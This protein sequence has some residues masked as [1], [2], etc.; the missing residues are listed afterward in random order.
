[1]DGAAKTNLYLLAGLLSLDVAE[2]MPA[3]RVRL[4]SMN[5]RKQRNCTRVDEPEPVSEH[6]IDCVAAESL[7][8]Q[9]ICRL[10]E[11]RPFGR[12]SM[13]LSSPVCV[14]CLDGRRPRQLRSRVSS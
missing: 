2:T 1:M 12:A 13:H 7:E 9:D 14:L 3:G 8:G 4:R 5:S 10:L 11:A 6:K